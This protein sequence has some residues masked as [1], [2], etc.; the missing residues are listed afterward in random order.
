L[1]ELYLILFGLAISSFIGSLSYR[2]PRKISM[3]K[4]PSYC[5]SCMRKLGVYELVPVL[6]YIALRGRCS[7]CRSTIPI[8]FFIVEIATPLL[9][10]ALYRRVGTG[11]SFFVYTYL[12]SLLLYLSLVDIDTGSVSVVDIAA[13]YVGGLASLF[14]SFR[15]ATAHDPAQSL[16]GFGLCL[17]LISLS[18]LILYVIKRRR[19]LGIGDLF[20]LPGIALYFGMYSI[21][22][23]LLFSAVLGL[24]TG[25]LLISLNKVDR[26]FKFPL[27]PFTAVGVCIEI[28]AFYSNISL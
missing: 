6:S 2:V 8:R 16:Y 14:L 28:L 17:G 13:V 4:P 19:T 11:P 26:D 15:G 3:L 20:I 1:I 5:P 24:I 23:I 27:M 25:V 21:I 18:V 22:R 7:T 10:L 9:Y 12:I